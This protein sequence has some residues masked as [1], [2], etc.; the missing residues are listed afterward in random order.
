VPLVV[1]FVVAAVVMISGIWL[2][3]KPDRSFI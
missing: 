1:G 2:R 3:R